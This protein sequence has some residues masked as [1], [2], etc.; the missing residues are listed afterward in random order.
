MSKHPLVWFYIVAFGISWLGW[1]PAVLG[2]HAIAPFDAPGFQS[3]LILPAVGPALAAVIVMRQAY[4][5][6]HV[7]KWFKALF[8]W[9]ASVRWYLVALFAP[10]ALLL[11]AQGLTK[12]FSLPVTQ[13]AFEGMSSLL[14]SLPLCFRCFPTRGKKL[15]GAVLPCRIYRNDIRQRL[16]PLLWAFC[17][18]YG[19]SLFSSG[20]TIQSRSILFC[21]GLSARWREPFFIPGCITAPQEVFFW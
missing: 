12:A 15:A 19:I 3:L 9:R 13:P 20:K 5:R 6:A 18:G 10:L 8:Q 14:R 7:E 11:L 16:P 17:G 1:I 4:G 2:S 21:P